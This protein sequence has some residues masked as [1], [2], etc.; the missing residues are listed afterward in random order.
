M[1]Q[2]IDLLVNYPKTKR[3]LDERSASKTEADRAIARQL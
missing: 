1:K 2:E 3:N